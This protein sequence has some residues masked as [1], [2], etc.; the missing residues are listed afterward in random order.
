ML[1]R[2]LFGL[3]LVSALAAPAVVRAASIMPVK[4]SPSS[5]S[6]LWLIGWGG[7]EADGLSPEL[8]EKLVRPPLI[9]MKNEAA[10]LLPGHFTYARRLKPPSVAYRIDAAWLSS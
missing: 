8:V 3:G 7:P 1:T 5:S 10:S 4:V 6:S 9:D 2:R